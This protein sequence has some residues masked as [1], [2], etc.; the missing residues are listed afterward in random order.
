MIDLRSLVPLDVDD[1]RRVGAPNRPGRGR[2]RGSPTR[3][4]SAPRSWRG[5]VEE[6]STTWRR[7]SL[8]VTGYDMPYPPATIERHYVPTPERIGA[9]IDRVVLVTDGRPRLPAARSGRGPGGRRGRAVAA[10]PRATASS[11]TRPLV[12]VNTAKALVEIPSPWAGVVETSA[13]RRGRRRRGREPLVSVRVD[14]ATRGG[15][16]GRVPVLVGYG[17]DED[18]P[19]PL[20]RA[21]RPSPAA[22]AGAVGCGHARRCAS[23]RRTSGSTSRRSHG[24]GPGRPH[25]PRGRRAGA[26][27]AG[28]GGAGGHGSLGRADAEVVPV[29]GIRRLIAER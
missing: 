12:E 8:R 24:S 27:A 28:A 6:A 21:R 26:T 5:I 1:A 20:P 14:E 11:S 19:T 9:A 25:H 2:P 13:R 18:R 4:G 10:W 15:A 22:E 7:P 3:S 29:R 16:G 23:W 17:V